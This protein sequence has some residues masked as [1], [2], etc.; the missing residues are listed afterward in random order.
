MKRN[1]LFFLDKPIFG[2]S[3]WWGNRLQIRSSFIRLFFIYAIFVNGFT[4]G[5][6]LLMLF[7]L[8]VRN[9]FKYQR[10]SVFDL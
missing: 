1:F 9:H 4:I 10:K 5:V 8:K 7:V 2:V 3:S 6:Y